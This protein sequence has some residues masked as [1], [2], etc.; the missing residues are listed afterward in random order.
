M[1]RD[2]DF[3]RRMDAEA[4]E[5]AE[6]RVRPKPN[7]P[8]RRELRQIELIRFTD[9]RPR[10][11]GKPL[12]K[13]F[14]EREQT[15]LIVG[16]MQT[17]KT[18]LALDLG[19]HVAAGREWFGRRVSL[20]AVV[21][22]ACEAGRSIINRVAAWKIA[23]GYEENTAIPF[24]AVTSPIDLCHADM[25]DLD[26][27]MATIRAAGFERGALIVIDTVSR[28][29]AG[30]DEN[31]PGDMG[32]IVYS[33]DRLRDE[34]H[35]HASAVHHFGKDTGRGAR[36]HSLLSANLD[37]VV[38]VS[39]DEAIKTSIATVT[40]QRDGATGATI[41]FRLR[42]IEL[43]RN[44]DGDPVTSCVVEAAEIQQ[45]GARKTKP[46]LSASQKRVL[47][48]LGEAIVRGGAVPPTCNHI[49]P[50]TRCVAEAVWRDYCYQGAVSDSDKPEAKQKA[51]RRA[52]N[53]LL[54]A[55]RVGK[56]GDYVWIVP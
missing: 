27:L 10:L 42:Q 4:A 20:G 32:A 16:A 51:F 15:S 53:D 29:L 50:N 49:P 45:V 24:A 55:G 6:F 13:D 25:S 34:F 8:A 52:A 36:G 26:R 7:E 28:A 35:C 40:K 48:L 14:L 1:S 9:M 33:L 47:E 18:F 31:S 19:L 2:D 5:E 11:D 44:K 12:V 46:P 30:G 21:Y 22:V 17:G 37:T 23:H 39:R 3:F 41:A 43:G 54:E 56:W 38:E